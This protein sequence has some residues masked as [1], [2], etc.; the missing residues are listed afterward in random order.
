MFGIS[1]FVNNWDKDIESLY[2][3]FTTTGFNLHVGI[4]LLLVAVKTGGNRMEAAPQAGP[5]R[6][7]DRAVGGRVGA[8]RREDQPFGKWVQQRPGLAA[9]VGVAADEAETPGPGRDATL[10]TRHRR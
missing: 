7:A 3:F 10:E 5:R 4:L 1:S 6:S 8:H 2:W 9:L